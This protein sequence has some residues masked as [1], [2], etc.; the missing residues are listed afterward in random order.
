MTICARQPAAGQ[1]EI[2][3]ISRPYSLFNLVD[4]RFESLPSLRRIMSQARVHK[5]STL[6]VENI[7]QAQDLDEENEDIKIR[8]PKFS[9]SSAY[10]LSFFAKHFTSQKHID[11]VSN[12]DFLGYAVIKNDVVPPVY[13][14]GLL[15]VYESVIC[16]SRHPNN[17][18]H[19]AQRWTVSVAGKEF[20]VDGYLYAQQNNMSNGCSHVALRTAIARFHP[21]GDMSY[22]EMNR[23]VGVDHKKRKVGGGDGGGLYSVEMIKI[24][25]SAGARCLVGDYMSPGDWPIPFDKYLYGSV[26]SGFPGIVIFSTTAKSGESHAIPV[27]GHTFN[28]DT[29]V[30][31]AESSYFH[32][33]KSTRYI[34]SDSW[35]SMYIAHDDNFGSNY[36]IPKR[37][38]EP[39]R[40]CAKAIAPPLFCPRDVKG[41]THV[42]ATIP[43]AVKLDP[44][45]AEIIGADY[46]FTILPQIPGLDNE[47]RSRFEQYATESAIILRPILVKGTD[48]VSHLSRIRDWERNSINASALNAIRAALN[49]DFVW[50]I[51]LSVPELFSANRRKLGEVLLSTDHAPG[52]RRDLSTFLVARVPGYFAYYKNGR[53]ENPRYGFIDTGLVSHTDLYG[54]EEGQPTA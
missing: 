16:P 5:A 48:Y 4:K 47:W 29:W 8:Y 40:V 15:R 37:Y 53:P 23:L 20:H 3:D 52:V 11:S 10:R 34:P 49:D 54:C 26:E 51:E 21:T 1:P 9:R 45:R 39:K 14:Y 24:L 32:V 27:F 17:Y 6:V 35:L 44:A 18:I 12:Q 46:L 7:K 38:L 22:R 13:P 41:V 30:W 36:C 19:G 33:G 2:I 50:L 43:M 25:E 28:E 42:I 31:N